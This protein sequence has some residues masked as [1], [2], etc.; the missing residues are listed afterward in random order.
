MSDEITFITSNKHKLQELKLILKNDNIVSEKIDLI[1]LQGSPQYISIEKCKYASSKLNNKTVLVEDTSLCFEALGGLPG[2]YIK[3]F[4]DN[5]GNDGLYKLLEG[6]SDK[7]A[8]ALC[9]F[10]LQEPGKPVQLFEGAVHGTIVKP[11]DSTNGFGWD[12]IFKPD[13]SE[14]TFAEMNQDEKNKI[15]HRKN[16]IDKLISYYNL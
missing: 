1:E 9:I 4:Y 14:L 2:P 12:N 3:H 15:S 7:R 11:K 13:N 16:A 8:Y 5:I 6:F 10:A